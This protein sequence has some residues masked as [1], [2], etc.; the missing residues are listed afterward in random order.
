[1]QLEFDTYDMTS[2]ENNNLLH[3]QV[4]GGFPSRLDF[5]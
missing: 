5:L 4:C 3:L 1:M 2:V